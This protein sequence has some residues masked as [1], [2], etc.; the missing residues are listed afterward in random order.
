MS[1][2]ALLDIMVTIS[3]ENAPCTVESQE[4]GFKRSDK[5]G[6]EHDNSHLNILQCAK[7]LDAILLMYV[8]LGFIYWFDKYKKYE[9]R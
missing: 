9:N 3:R 2:D 8:I 1:P 4:A 6:D 7:P 5:Q